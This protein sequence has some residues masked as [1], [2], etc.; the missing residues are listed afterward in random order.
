MIK[1]TTEKIEAFDIPTQVKFFDGQF[2][3]SEYWLIGIGYK[4]EIICG[5]CGSVFPIDQIYEVADEAD[6][7]IVDP[8]QPYKHWI[9]FSE[10]I[11]GEYNLF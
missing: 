11:R 2:F 8:I 5:C 4:D 3:D 1:F 9:D 6:T 7:E 10:D